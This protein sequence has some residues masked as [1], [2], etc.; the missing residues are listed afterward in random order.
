MAAPFLQIAEGFQAELPLHVTSFD[1][2]GDPLDLPPV[3]LRAVVKEIP[4]PGELVR[5]QS[6]LRIRRGERRLRFTVQDAVHDKLLWGE[7]P[8]GGA[9]RTS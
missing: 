3:V 5:F 4:P 8:I 6:T 1:D 7:G 9:K 2:T